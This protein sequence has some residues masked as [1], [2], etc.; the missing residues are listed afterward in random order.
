MVGKRA[1]GYDVIVIGSGSGATIV[2]SALA[3]GFKVAE[4]DRGPLGGTCLNVGCIPS[5]ML[6]VPAD[7]VMEIQEAEKLGI[8]A[9]IDHIDFQSIME[10]MRRLIS[11]DVAGIREATTSAAGLDF[12]EAEGHFVSKD[13]LQVGDV[14]IKGKRL[15]IAS[16]SRPLLPPIK[17]I[18]EI[19]YLTNESVLRLEE[20]PE[21]LI[22][23]GGGYISAE[24]AH[25]FSAMGTAVTI[26]G[27][28]VRLV[29]DE[30][31]EVSEILKRKLAERMAVFTGIEIIEAEEHSE[32]VRVI[33]RDNGTG[34]KREFTAERVMIAAGRRSN[35][36]TLKVENAGIET[37]K[38]G[39]IR[40]NGYFET[41][42]K[43]IW[44]F[45]DVIGK[46]L[47]THVA[48][49]EAVYAWHNSIHDSKV[50]MD[51]S[52]IPHAVFSHPQ[53][54]SVGLT[55]A[56]AKGD[57]DILV[58][59]ARYSDVAKGIAMMETDGFA[60]AILER[61]TRKI[62]GFHII[63]PYAPILIQEVIDVM[64]N[65]GVSGWVSEGMHIHPAMP[66]VVVRTLH[67]LSEPHT[68]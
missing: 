41:N 58:G 39:S 51:Y 52:A 63:G 66:E 1:K 28:N 4:V 3:H 31:P 7:R 29:P 56:E 21:S 27:R 32:G 49:R 5:K 33:G 67:N 59:R 35:A 46:H 40:V 2:E 8:H 44:A 15:Y 62:L 36:D 65:E 37:D 19:E 11:H 64:A 55:E 10:R 45:G 13:T 30:E 17:G 47:F 48:N 12:Y 20:K 24:Y 53:I 6:I 14:R 43:N 61:E 22:I 68:H 26:V 38:R 25:F 42:V 9:E 57:H 16:G 18:D 23:I 50:E 54:A 60:K 34:E